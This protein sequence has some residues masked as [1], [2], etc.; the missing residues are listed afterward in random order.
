M[1]RSRSDEDFL[2]DAL[3]CQLPVEKMARFAQLLHDGGK[4]SKR[5][6]NSGRHEQRSVKAKF[7]AFTC[8][9]WKLTLRKFTD[10]AGPFGPLLQTIKPK[11]KGDEELQWDFVDPA[12]LFEKACSVSAPLHR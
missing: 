4:R 11:T 10:D 12:A 1:K 5:L 2:T 9:Q 6:L 3:A 7:G 8:R